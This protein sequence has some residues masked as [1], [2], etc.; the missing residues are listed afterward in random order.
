VSHSPALNGISVRILPPATL[1][2]VLLLLSACSF[3]EE[4]A[5]VSV[6]DRSDLFTQVML[7]GY[8]ERDYLKFSRHFDS[9]LKG[10]LPEP[11]FFA[12]RDTMIKLLGRFV[13]K[14]VDHVEQDGSYR[15]VYYRMRFEH[16]TGSLFKVVLQPYWDDHLISGFEFAGGQPASSDPPDDVSGSP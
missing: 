14:E 13:A 4:K 11:A 6:L 3:E 8:N 10:D 15:V 7:E 16:E 2:A 5:P 1:L 12:F 9:S